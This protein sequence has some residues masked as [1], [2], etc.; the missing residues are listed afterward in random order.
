V[1]Y[2]GNASAA[3]PEKIVNNY[4]T[5]LII[6][7]AKVPSEFSSVAMSARDKHRGLFMLAGVA[8]LPLITHPS[9]EVT[10]LL[11]SYFR[12]LI[13]KKKSCGCKGAIYYFSPFIPPG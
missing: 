3:G 11:S 1:S 13:R 2:G 12:G 9:S 4:K 8:L 10:A 5:H 7:W 6:I